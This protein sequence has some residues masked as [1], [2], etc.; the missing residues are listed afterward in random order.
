F[1][2]FLYFLSSTIFFKCVIVSILMIAYINDFSA[3]L[4]FLVS[5]LM[6]LCHFEFFS[7]YINDFSTF[8]PA[9]FEFLIRFLVFT[10]NC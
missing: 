1:L 6:I 8:L 4:N 7:A 5:I 10:V 3:I 9:Y 2:Y